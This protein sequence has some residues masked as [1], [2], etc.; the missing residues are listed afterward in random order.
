[1]GITENMIVIPKSVH[2]K[3]MIENA[4]IFDFELSSLEMEEMNQLNRNERFGP[5]PDTFEKE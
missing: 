4:D 3:R 2:K 1:M 5:N